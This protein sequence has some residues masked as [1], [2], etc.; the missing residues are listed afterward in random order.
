M[1]AMMVVMPSSGEVGS[2]Y[3]DDSL[4]SLDEGW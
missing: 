3:Y 4:P 1:V 2:S